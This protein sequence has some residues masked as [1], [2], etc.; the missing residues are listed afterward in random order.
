MAKKLLDLGGYFYWASAAQLDPGST[1]YGT[2]LYDTEVVPLP[3]DGGIL[4]VEDNSQVDITFSIYANPSLIPFSIFDV[5]LE[6]LQYRHNV[7]WGQQDN[8]WIAIGQNAGPVDWADPAAIDITIQNFGLIGRLAFEG[9]TEGIWFDAEPYA[10]CGIWD[11]TAMPQAGTYTFEQYKRFTYLAA[12]QVATL[13]KGYFP[14]IKIMFSKSYARYVEEIQIYGSAS[15]YGLYGSFLDGVYDGL[16][17]NNGCNIVCPGPRVV[18]T[19]N[20]FWAYHDEASMQFAVERLKGINDR[21]ARGNSQYF[22]SLTDWGYACWPDLPGH[23]FPTIFPPFDNVNTSL[24]QVAPNNL[25]AQLEYYLQS[26]D[27]IWIFNQYYNFFN[28]ASI[29]N[30]KYNNALQTVRSI[31]GMKGG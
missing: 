13:W 10:N 2:S 23:D 16:G 30:S 8:N 1:V 29:I 22:G 28:S 31:F 15:T 20:Y 3:L 26:V 18:M 14:S 17:A 6:R 19:D 12:V 25:Q 24:S 27:Y 11:Y 4:G 7:G 9:K 21:R 5:M